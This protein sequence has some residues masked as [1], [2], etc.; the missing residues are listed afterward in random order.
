V[1]AIQEDPARDKESIRQIHADLHDYRIR[2]MD[3][4][5][6]KVNIDQRR[7]LYET[8]DRSKFVK[9]GDVIDNFELHD[10]VCGPF[11]IDDIL[12][13]S[14]LSVLIFFRFAGCPACNLALPF[15]NR[16]L[17]PG[18][19]AL[20]VSLIA[21]S[22]QVP[23]RLVEIKTKH[24]L[25]FIVSSDRNN[26]LAH[27]F[28]IVFTSNEASRESAKRK[29]FD[30]PG[31]LGTGTWEL[32]H[33]T[34]VVIDQTKTVRFVDVTPDWLERTEAAVILKAVKDIIG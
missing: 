12:R 25:E 13:S 2:T 26:M 6:L 11:M 31:V 33:P 22:P 30:F 7:E 24:G 4:A 1:N 29:G 16:N 9:I 20:G 34:V 18:L 21:V 19:R 15:Y 14:P 8:A 5:D 3:P 23:E 17:F 10:V 32:P 28:G 27:R